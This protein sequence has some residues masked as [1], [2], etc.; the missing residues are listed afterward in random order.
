[1]F[2][3]NNNFI[4]NVKDIRLVEIEIFSYCN[5]QCWFCPNSFIDRHS[6]NNYMVEKLYLKI[7]SEL[8]SINYSS[9]ISYS[10]YN[11]PT[12][13]KNIFIKRLKQAKKYL[14]NALL[15]TNTNGDYINRDYL[16]ELYDSGLKSMNIQYYLNKYDVFDIQKIKNAIQKMSDKLQ[17]QFEEILFSSDRYEV[18]FF[19]KDMSLRMYSRDFRING[20][21]RG[22]SLNTISPI[23][24]TNECYIPFTDIYIDY[25][26]M[27]MPCCNFRSDID[28]HKHFIIGNANNDNIIE[29]FNNE[30]IQKLRYNLIN[31]I[32]NITPCNEC[33]FAI[34]YRPDQTRPDQTRPDQT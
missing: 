16:D 25:N 17:L 1:M 11:E 5:R 10:R 4:V 30:L 19:Y 24:R 13:N 8:K 9:I 20:T 22:G 26:G 15:H 2:S 23:K 33:N 21:N 14:P 28:K 6:N 34:D 3:R 32:T 18:K 27:V 29:I 31:N 7:L 12:S